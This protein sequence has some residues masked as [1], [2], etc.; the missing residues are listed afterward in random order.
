MHSVTRK[1]NTIV[2]YF[3]IQLVS[4]VLR[5]HTIQ[6][7][8][9]SAWHATH[10]HTHTQACK[11]GGQPINHRRLISLIDDVKNAQCSRARDDKH[12]T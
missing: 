7:M 1:K 8:K 10:T 5:W 2:Q 6:L 9:A 4:V 12:S 11:A 3:H